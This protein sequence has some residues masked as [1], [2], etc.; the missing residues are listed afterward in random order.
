MSPPPDAGR[1]TSFM[2]P[3]ALLTLLLAV[4]RSLAAEVPLDFSRTN[5]REIDDMY[6]IA[7]FLRQNRGA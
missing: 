3:G 5:G 6:A 1:P 2:R 7:R 4:G